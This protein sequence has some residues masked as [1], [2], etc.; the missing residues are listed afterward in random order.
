MTSL[1]LIRHGETD[2]N[3]D[4]RIQGASDIPLN[5]TGRAQ[6]RT[7]GE[8]LA[9][10]LPRD[11]S[12]VIVASDL[13]RARETAEII[14]DTLGLDEPR[15]YPELRE[16]AYGQGEG[17][18]AEQLEERWGD[19]HASAVPGAEHVDVVRERALAG[20]R[21]AVADA[22]AQAAPGPVEVV[23]VS[24]GALIRALV[25]HATGGDR[26]GSGERLANGSGYTF[27]V[28]RDRLSLVGFDVLAETDAP[29]SNDGIVIEQDA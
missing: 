2:W 24:H 12:V 20:V 23:G 22:R 14:A 15:L 26:P 21:R 17:L 6:A 4:G 11:R 18:N 27:L 28:E 3:R 1:T 13:S 7:A 25:R 19:R 29:H 9:R 10:L 16:R 5:D 8:T